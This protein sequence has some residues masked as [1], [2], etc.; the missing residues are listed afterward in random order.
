[1]STQKYPENHV[2]I[3]SKLVHCMRLDTQK[4]D[5]MQVWAKE[6]P[7]IQLQQ[8]VAQAAS[9]LRTSPKT[10]EGGGSNDF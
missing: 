2:L 5:G 6:R 4:W 7:P 3:K 10:E 9:L 1:M 8:P